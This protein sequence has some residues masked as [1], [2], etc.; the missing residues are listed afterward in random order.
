MTDSL[1]CIGTDSVTVTIDTIPMIVMSQDTAVCEGSCVTIS[2]TGGGTYSWTPA[3]TLSDTS[4][5]NPVAC[6]TATTTYYVTVGSATCTNN[7]SVT[8]TVNPPA[9]IVT[10]NDTAI[11][12]GNCVQ[13]NTTGGVSYLWT[14]STGL[15]NDTIANP[16]ACPLVTTTYVV[17][18]IDTNGCVGTDTVTITI[19]PL[20]I[21]DA[22]PDQSIC[23]VGSVVIG[24]T[25]T[26]PVGS[27]YSWSPSGSLNDTTLANPTASPVSTTTYTVVV[28]DTNGCQNSD[29]VTVTINPLPT[30]DAGPDSTICEG[31]T[32][33]IGGFPTGPS[34]SS[35][36]WTPSI[37][38]DNDTLAN[39]NATPTITTEYIV[40]VTDSNGCVDMD[41]VLITVNPLP[42]ITVNNDTS[43]CIGAC[44]QLSA[45][46]ATSYIW[47]PG[48]TL[49]D[50]TNANPVACPVV[51]TTYIVTGTDA[52]SCSDTA[53][54]TVT[55]NPLPTVDAGPD[56]A[57][58]IGDSIIIG[59][60]PTGPTGSSYV[61]VPAASLDDDTLANPTAFPVVTT[62]YIV[63][64]TDSNGCIA[65]DTVEVTVNPLPVADAGIDTAIC[66]GVTVQIG[67]TPTGPIGSS[68][69]WTPSATLDDDTLANPNA[70]PPTTTEYIV[71]VTDSNGC[72]DMDSITIVVNPLPTVS[73][74]PD[75]AMCIGAC[76]QLN[77]SGA[78][79]Y[80]WTPATGL[81][82]DTIANPLACPTIT[83]NYIVAGTDTNGCVDTSATLVTI[84]P[85]PT[86][87][88]SNDT[89][90]CI[91]TCAQLVANGGTGYVWTPG[92]TL[93]DSTI[94]NPV[95]CPTSLTTYLVTV[96][97]SNS[98]VDTATVTII[99]DSLPTID[100][101]PDTVLCIGDSIQL[102]ATGGTSYV[103]TPNTAISDT[104]ISNPIVF[105]T[106]TTT[107]YVLGTDSNGCE[108]L[109]S[110]VVTVNPLP[111][112][113]TSNDTA[114]CLGDCAQLSASGGS[115]YTWTPGATLSD[116]TIFNPVACPTIN[117]TY[118]VTVTD[119]NSCTDTASV[120]VDINPLPV[121]DAGPD[122]W[123]CSGDS[124]QLNATG[125]I[126]Y[127]WTPSSGLSDTTIA[128]PWAFPTD[129][130]NYIVTGTDTNGCSNTDTLQI[131]VN[132]EVPI[133]P[134][135]DT[136]ICFGDTIMLGGNPT[137][138]NG[139][140]FQ[141]FPNAG[142][143]DND[144]SA[145]PNAFPTVTTTYYVVATNDTCTAIDSI[146]ITV[147]P[148]PPANAGSDVDICFGDTVQ[149]N[150][151][152]GIAY[153]WQPGATLSDSTINNP[154]AFPNDTTSYIVEV[155]DTNGCSAMDTMVVNV[156]PLPIISA[157]A[158]VSVCLGDSIQLNATGG[159]S[160]VW[161]P[162]AGLS[163][164]T[165]PNPLASPAGTT[166]YVVT[167]TD[168]LGCSNIDSVTVTINQLNLPAINDTTICIGES[169]QLTVNG[170]PGATYAWTPTIDLSD[171]TIFNPITTTQVTI[172]YLVT[173]TDTNGC[174]DTASILVVAEAKPTADYSMDQTP[175]CDGMLVDFTN[176]SQGA[177]SYAWDFNDGSYSIEI[178]PSHTFAY[179]SSYNVMLISYTNGLCSDT[180]IYPVLSGQFEDYFNLVPPSVVTPNGDG[181]NDLFRM[182]VPDNLSE[183]VSIQVFNR[184]GMLIFESDGQN[185]GWN[186]RTTAGK[187]VPD[188]TYF[189]II[190]I[191]GMVKKGSLTLMR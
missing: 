110:V 107:Y 174:S 103:W 39:P 64:V 148:P 115:S 146:T 12:D 91:G 139:T 147:N 171:S 116:S 80:V 6:P 175:S 141:W 74:S 47:T 67:G 128:N 177:V 8:I 182:D 11:C 7:D 153:L 14:P 163:N 126:N 133:D 102:N 75:T 27:S 109:D 158:G 112:I 94:A 170:P 118:L 142:T 17:T 51:T 96:T 180:A 83:T 49:N 185:G 70:T 88:I 25:P 63:V 50:S 179:G 140:S 24:G 164:D 95:A 176:L 138:P 167:G 159:I 10:N 60:A 54:I 104:S 41:S 160:Y 13:L 37:S 152:G 183:C 73:S 165:I 79:T 72:M 66:N 20:P 52:N 35:Y 90:V 86:V 120:N 119:S 85:L 40:T 28:T 38:L 130:S 136:T 190:D 178:D 76:Y 92:T 105:P 101:G 43:V 57:I 82:N 46:G 5:S 123:L 42:V 68:Y 161:T 124:I 89:S 44:A 55:I 129:T 78:S 143:L 111:S 186:G 150:A 127:S 29:V 149:L 31:E 97:D 144:T 121:I 30:A 135:M 81:S 2:A 132:D 113:L 187:Q 53:S 156:N 169:L 98:C 131:I 45:S 84:N 173:V 18:G 106:V 26:G 151:S 122:L 34:G 108:N 62:S 181:F 184:W 168:A 172:T 191:N 19:N 56:V 36:L 162:S 65:S 166:T 21:I 77:A 15:S 33:Q 189:Y 99:V 87:T 22:G 48:S 59:G 145:N 23:N 71:T 32:I 125:G 16:L 157:G 154:F 117:T 9:T 114:I 100:A 61:W 1:G 58:C 188:G 137:S 155:T 93:N 4:I 134:G 69:S 3:A